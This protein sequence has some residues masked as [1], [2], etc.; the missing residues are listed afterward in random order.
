MTTPGPRVVSLSPTA[1]KHLLDTNQPCILLD[2]RE[3]AERALCMISA[4]RPA[5]DVF[6]PLRQIPANLDTLALALADGQRP[7]VVYC[8]H[9][10]RSLIAARWLAAQGFD[11]LYNLEGGIDAYSLEGDPSV[12]RY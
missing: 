9:G 12:S 4:P 2:V 7:L 5:R 8:H 6:I 1:L 3:P 10:V 11:S